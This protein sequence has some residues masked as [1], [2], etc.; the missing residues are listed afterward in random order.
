MARSVLSLVRPVESGVQRPLDL[1]KKV[2]ES[3][4]LREIRRRRLS[5][6][7]NELLTRLVDQSLVVVGDPGLD[8]AHRK[9]GRRRGRGHPVCAS[10]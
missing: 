9:L 7:T 3:S 1:R 10:T 6:L 5:W 8:G 4:S 2:R